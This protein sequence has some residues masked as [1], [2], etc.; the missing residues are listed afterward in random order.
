MLRLDGDVFLFGTAIAAPLIS[1]KMAT[2]LRL[3][4]AGGAH[5]GGRIVANRG[6]YSESAAERKAQAAASA[7]SLTSGLVRRSWPKVDIGPWPGTKAVSS[8]SGQSRVVI[9]SIRS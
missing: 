2:I 7:A 3:F 5:G 8:P 9:A 4:P 1:I 6:S